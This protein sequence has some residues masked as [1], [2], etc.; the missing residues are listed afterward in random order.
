MILPITAF[1]PASQPRVTRSWLNN[2]S[3]GEGDV[4]DFDPLLSPHAYPDGID[5]GAIPNESE[6]QSTGSFGFG[7]I[8]YEEVDASASSRTTSYDDFDPTLS[9]HDYPRGVDAGVAIEEDSRGDS[10]QEKLGILLIDHGSKREASN[11]HLH[12]LA[13]I[14]QY[15]FSES[16]KKQNTVVRGAHMEIADPSILTS[17]RNL[18]TMDQVTRIVCVP[19]F[20]SPGRHATTDVPNLLAEAK[21]VL[22]KEGVMSQE[23]NECIEIIMSDALG[24]HTESMLDAVD[25]LV[26]FALDKQE[27]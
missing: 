25:K 23:G 15:N 27:S 9:P 1:V 22:S 21:T 26:Y 5:S 4:A 2:Q 13:K 14:Y 3:S 12:N 8:K 20:L 7:S 19:Y 18:I 24:T 11:E 17:L 6:E 10:K 16:K